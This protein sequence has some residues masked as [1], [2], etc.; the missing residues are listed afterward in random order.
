MWGQSS[1]LFAVAG[2]KGSTQT[3]SGSISVTASYGSGNYSYA[4]SKVSGYGNVGSVYPAN[5]L[6]VSWSAVIPSISTNYVGT[7]QCIITDNI[8]GS[9]QTIQVNVSF[10]FDNNA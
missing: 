3:A 10:E 9:S 8:Y 5:V 6:A 1:Y 7:Y 2:A 4:F